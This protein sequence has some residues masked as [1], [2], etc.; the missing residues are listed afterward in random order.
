MLNLLARPRVTP[1]YILRAKYSKVKAT[2]S[3][4]N[5]ITRPGMPMLQR[6]A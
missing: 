3:V 6:I 1:T 4:L 2:C 5:R